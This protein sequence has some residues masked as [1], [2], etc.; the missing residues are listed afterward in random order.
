MIKNSNKLLIVTTVPETLATI[1]KFQPK[2]LSNFFDVSLV[3]SPSDSYDQVLKNEGIPIF[4][5]PMVR[6]ISIFNDLV[7]VVLMVRLLRNI[8]PLLVHSY[9][10]KAGLVSMLA[11]WL[12]RVP[13]RVHTFTGLISPTAQGFKKQLLIWVDR[14]ICACATHIVPEGEGVK[15]DLLRLHISQKPLHVIGY[16]NIAGVDTSYFSPNAFGVKRAGF[17]L[18]QS[19]EI[20]AGDF[21]FCFIGRL[22]R[23]KGLAELI[24]AL[25]VLPPSAHLVLVGGVDQTAPVDD[26]TLKVIQSHSRVHQLGF[27]SDIRPALSAADVLVLPSYRE[28]FPNVVLQAASMSLPVI[29][30]N[31]NGCNEA[32]EPGYNGWLVPPRDTRALEA[33][34]RQAMETPAIVRTEM[35]RRGRI[36]IQHRFERIQHWKRMVVFYQKL[37]DG[38]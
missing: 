4:A 23:D 2:Y 30:T 34:M 16:G 25:R 18:R 3:T 38:L 37:F 6:G 35:G 11:A 8:R 5:I 36:R 32:V 12:C 1:L 28:G 10:P 21:L 20:D 19:I 29:A 17:Q 9:T 15:K 27:L 24:G 33:S 13:I 31:I 26:A 7:S 22:N 14:I